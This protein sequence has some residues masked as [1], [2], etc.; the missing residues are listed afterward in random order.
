MTETRISIAR[1]YLFRAAR[2]ARFQRARCWLDQAGPGDP[3]SREK[4][5]FFRDTR[6]IHANIH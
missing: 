5:F 1:T 4:P 2:S 3:R 6:H